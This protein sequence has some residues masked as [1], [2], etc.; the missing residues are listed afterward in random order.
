MGWEC[1]FLGH[2]RRGS[3]RVDG[4]AGVK[5]KESLGGLLEDL[6]GHTEAVC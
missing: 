6:V 5:I 2:T 1:I 4:R 3:V